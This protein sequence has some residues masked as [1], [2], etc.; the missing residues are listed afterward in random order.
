VKF[1]LL[2]KDSNEN[3]KLVELTQ[4]LPERTVFKF[5]DIQPIPKMRCFQ[6]LRMPRW[7]K[8]ATHYFFRAT[9]CA[10]PLYSEC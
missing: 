10:Q 6:N 5:C 7:P 1:G 8:L 3:N 2:F 4:F 9:S